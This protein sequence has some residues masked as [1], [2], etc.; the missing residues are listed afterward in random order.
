LA[1]KNV[2]LR[3]QT[4]ARRWNVSIDDKK[5]SFENFLA[6]KNLELGSFYSLVWFVMGN[7]GDDYCIEITSP[8]EAKLKLSRKLDSSRKDAGQVWFKI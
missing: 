4:N 1:K 2:E 5:I 7:E 3:F 6:N 8:D